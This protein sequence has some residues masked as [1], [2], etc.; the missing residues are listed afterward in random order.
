M[1]QYLKDHSQKKAVVLTARVHPGE[2]QAS[3]MLEGSLQVLLSDSDLARE[4]RRHFVFRVV[5]ML[6]PDGVVQGNYRCSLLGCDLNRKWL[7]PNKHLHPSIYYSKQLIKHAHQERKVL[8]YCDMHG[9]SR[10]QNVFFY[11]CAYKNYEF[12]GRIKNAQLRILPLLCCH[13]DASFSF[14]NSTFRIENA[15]ESTGRVVV[16]R[17]FNIMNSFTLECSFHGRQTLSGVT[18]LTPE[19]MREVGRTLVLA[20]ENYLPREQSKLSIIGG[21]VLD[22]FYDEFIK[23]VPFY[24]LKKEEQKQPELLQ[25]ARPD[26]RSPEPSDPEF[27]DFIAFNDKKD[28]FELTDLEMFINHQYTKNKDVELGSG[29][30]DSED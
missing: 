22:I 2:P 1:V 3:F 18:H 28:D 8:L 16:F 5:P 13:K 7:L 10:K 17:E 20:L 30:S 21:K 26:K 29:D 9:H 14:A 23:F 12:E 11:G 25:R 19:H 27:S 15:K 4:L 24:I 6:N